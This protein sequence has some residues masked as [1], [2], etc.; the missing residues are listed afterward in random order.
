[1]EPDFRIQMVNFFF[2]N[3]YFDLMPKVKIFNFS[4]LL[5]SAVHN[6]I[7]S[8]ASSFAF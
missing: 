4:D 7:A 8:R 3:Q 6:C 5:P 1:M 2:C